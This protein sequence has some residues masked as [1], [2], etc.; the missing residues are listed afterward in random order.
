MPRDKK[1]KKDKCPGDK[2]RFPCQNG[3]DRVIHTPIP[4]ITIRQ[5]L[6]FRSKDRAKSSQ[7][8]LHFEVSCFISLT[9]EW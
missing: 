5:N 9:S 4:T 1:K 3:F 7:T 6:N 8:T 2:K